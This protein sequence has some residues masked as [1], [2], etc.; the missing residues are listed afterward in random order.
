[1]TVSN[2]AY[3]ITVIKNHEEVWEQ[4]YQLTQLD[5]EEKVIFLDYQE[6]EDPDEIKKYAPKFTRFSTGDGVKRTFGRVMWNKEG[7][8]FYES[9]KL[10]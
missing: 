6:L 1:M 9:A 5:N 8:A 10:E 3:C 2:I 7:I 4:S